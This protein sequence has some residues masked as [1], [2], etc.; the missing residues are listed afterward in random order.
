MRPGK[1]VLIAPH[2]IEMLRP[3]FNGSPCFFRRSQDALPVRFDYKSH[4]QVKVARV[5]R[6]LPKDS[7]LTCHVAAEGPDLS[8]LT[9][10]LYRHPQPNGYRQD[11]PR[12]EE[13]TS[14]LQSQSNL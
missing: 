14:E 4:W 6:R 12:S 5:L 7:T 1:L 3:I 8:I 10:P 2:I 11:A 13:H 9:L